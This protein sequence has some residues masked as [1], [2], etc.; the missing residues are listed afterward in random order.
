MSV[1]AMIWSELRIELSVIGSVLP[2]SSEPCRFGNDV[3][4]GVEPH[5]HLLACVISRLGTTYNTTC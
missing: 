5:R 2:R 1:A 3:R 4:L